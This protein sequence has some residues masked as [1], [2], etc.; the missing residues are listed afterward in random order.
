MYI[1]VNFKFVE[2][3]FK[4]HSSFGEAIYCKSIDSDGK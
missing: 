3:D 1:L 2:K 4:E